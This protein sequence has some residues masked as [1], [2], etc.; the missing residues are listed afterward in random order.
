[1]VDH[2]I[3]DP[4]QRVLLALRLG[5]DGKTKALGLGVSELVFNEFTKELMPRDL[6]AGIEEAERLGFAHV[7]RA[8]WCAQS[9]T[10]KRPTGLRAIIS[11]SIT[12]SGQDYC[13]QFFSQLLRLF[14]SLGGKQYRKYSI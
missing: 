5:S 13:D 14:S 8:V 9:G 6:L 1:M 2:V 7:N 11:I 10:P 4:A 12:E 3:S